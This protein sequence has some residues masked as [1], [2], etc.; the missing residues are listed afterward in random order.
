[1][2]KAGTRLAVDHPWRTIIWCLAAAILLMPLVA[3]QFTDEVRWTAW[4][5]AAAGGLLIGAIGLYE[6]AARVLR[7]RRLL[8]LIAAVLMLMVLLIWAEGAVGIFD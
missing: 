2:A 7:D 8:P 3:M 6:V 4:D 5:F 1:M